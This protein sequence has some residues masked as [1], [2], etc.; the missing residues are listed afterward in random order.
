MKRNF[1]FFVIA[2]VAILVAGSAYAFAA[3][4]TI[5]ASAAGYKDSAVSGYDIVNIVYDLDADDPTMVDAITFDVH[6]TT[7]SVVA[8]IVKIQTADS[9]TWKDCTLGTADGSSRPV[10]CTYG[11]L[12]LI[13]VTALNVVASSSADPS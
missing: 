5:A 7:G 11:A 6:P 12:E 2:L 8:A 1:K 4:N 10:T 9:G 3:E 13:D